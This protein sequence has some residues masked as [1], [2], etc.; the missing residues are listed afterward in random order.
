V[1][2]DVSFNLDQGEY[3]ALLGPNG[4]G[5][6]TLLKTI[7]TLLLPTAGQIQVGGF[8]VTK[9]GREARSLSAYVLADDRSFYWRLSGWQN[10]QFFAALNGIH[11]T[12]ARARIALL[13]ERLNLLDDAERSFAEFSTGM[14]QRLAVARALISRPSVLLM[15]E[16]TRSVDGIHAAEVWKLVHEE[17]AEQS[18]CLIFV[19]HRLEEALWL[20]GRVIGLESGQIALDRSAEQIKSSISALEGF[21][22]GVRGLTSHALLSLRKFPGV[23]NMRI[24]S[25]NAD[26]QIL[27][28]SNPD[29]DLP[30]APFLDEL[31]DLGA[32]ICSVQRTT[33][34]PV[35]LTR[36]G[37]TCD[38]QMAAR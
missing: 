27:E 7:A 18:G 13:L 31:A 6:T 29:G 28:V 36:L 5:K 34:L 3:L 11:G 30:I 10:M 21:T 22:I 14:K 23:R 19:T 35:V 32:T 20:C 17:I 38:G 12:A 4:A 1:L 15:D 8:D 33:P 37:L 26:E 2:R 25:Q 24:A 16:P 9:Q